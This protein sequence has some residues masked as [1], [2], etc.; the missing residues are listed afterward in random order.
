MQTPNTILI[1]DDD[2]YARAMV[3][4]LLAGE[5]HRLLEAGRGD[6]ALRMA[7]EQQPDLILLDVM[8]P[9]FDGFEVCRNLRAN[10]QTREIAIILI[11]ALNDHLSRM[12]GLNAG[13]DGFISKPFDRSELLAQ[14]RTILKLNRYR[15]LLDEQAR[16]ER[17]IQLSPD[18]I[19]TLTA[20]GDLLLANLALAGLLDVERP[21]ELIGQNLGAFLTVDSVDRYRTG[22]ELVL[23]GAEPTARIEVSMRSAAQRQIPV[24]LNL[25]SF[26][27][28]N[29][30]AL[31]AIVRDI[32]VRKQ[33]ETQIQRQL[34]QLTS[35]HAIGV[36]I[37]ASLDLETTIAVL[38]DR[39]LEHLAF[40]AVS[41]LPLNPHTQMLDPATSRGLDHIPAHQTPVPHD[42]SLPGIAFLTRRPVTIAK[43]TGK[44]LRCDRDQS[45]AEHFTSY[46]AMP[47]IARDRV[48]GVIEV[49]HCAQ[50]APDYHWSAFFE[51]LAVQAAIAIDTAELFAQIQQAHVE[52]AH[53]YNATIEGWSRA[54]DMR[55]HET[56][57]H[58]TRVTEMALH[59]ARRMQ[60]S[61]ED[62]DHIRRGALL[63]DIGKMG[64]P[65]RILLKPGPLTSDEWQV[66]R[67]HPSY[68]YQWLSAIPFLHPA[69][70]IP[71]AHHERWDGSGYP[72]GL[73]GDQIPLAARI[74]A[75]VDVW[76]ALRSVRPYRMPW[77]E[78]RVLDHIESLSG[79]HFDPQVVVVFLALAREQRRSA[80]A[81]GAPD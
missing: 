12:Q 49:M 22:V 21:D 74:F 14:V 50:F 20:D 2:V 59:L 7:S 8:M 53:S 18:G 39:M 26:S 24:E 40:D 4:Q 65:D 72:R 23:S 6:E 10:P 69:L 62:L 54:L 73:S 71:Y 16:F 78:D 25:G 28:Q 68:A 33:A 43:L 61:P 30:A 34:S 9:G 41:V 45:L 66:M 80:I 44:E 17:L 3:R 36:A 57:G 11:T 64:V 15:R 1:V 52:L 48:L 58:S 60:I 81:G 47:L 38:L 46:L 70:S 67:Q 56:E 27:D 32:S 42:D 79:S 55:D 35:L 37:T 77:P 31:Q 75:V 51:A 19:A 13:T 5:K 76:D 29:G 63:H